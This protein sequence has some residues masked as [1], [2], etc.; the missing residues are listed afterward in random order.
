LWVLTHNETNFYQ[1]RADLIAWRGSFSGLEGSCN[2][3][4]M[5]ETACPTVLIVDDS[6]ENLQVLS[7]LL[8]LQYRVLAAPSGQAALRIAAQSPKPDLILLDVMMPDMDGYAVLAKLRDTPQTQDIPV[9]FLTA[10]NSIED[11][12]KG[13]SLGAVDYIT[14]PINPAI[15][16]ARVCTQ[17][18]LKA[19][20]D[21]LTHQKALLEEQV[22]ERTKALTAALSKVED[23]YAALQKAYFGTLMA[24]SA[25]ADMRGPAIGQHARRVADISRKV[26][27]SMGM[28]A[29]QVQNVFAAALM[30]DIG[31]IGFPD[32]LLRKPLSTMSRDD[33]A[34]HRRHPTLAAKALS[35]VEALREIAS[36][37]HHHHENY[38]GSGYPDRQSGMNIPMGSRIIA[39]VSDYDDCRNGALTVAP[40]SRKEA[41]RY[42]I[43]G[44]G[45]RYDP[46]VVDRV[47]PFL[48]LSEDDEIKEVKLTVTGLIEGMVLTRDVMH[49]DGF[50]LVS[51]ETVLDRHLIDQ[52][53]ALHKDI[54]RA[55]ELFVRR[56]Q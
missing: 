21:K 27:E 38:D 46:L 15:V 24:I 22:A 55:L 31:T 39:A 3:P 47:V 51:K 16:S 1:H 5:S 11:E 36:I 43:D 18:E 41:H 9:V 45:H 54:K 28:T 33:L 13:L 12:E 25:I 42:L 44:R 32:E 17:L 50:M 26:A 10:M 6:P 2:R 52:L 19:A 7:D 8:R 34:T 48:G 53:L 49:P 20:R 40:L 37:V 4:I 30:H 56:E 35:K 14:K 29:V 23:T